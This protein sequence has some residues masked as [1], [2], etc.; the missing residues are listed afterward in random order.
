[1]NKRTIMFCTSGKS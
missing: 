1:M